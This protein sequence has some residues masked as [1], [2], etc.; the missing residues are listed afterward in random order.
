LH[1]AVEIDDREAGG[2]CVADELR[3]GA[4][5]DLPGG[6]GIQGGGVEVD[7]VR[8]ED[9]IGSDEG[10]VV[11]EKT[12]IDSGEGG[13]AKGSD[14]N[15]LVVPVRGPSVEYGNERSVVDAQGWSVAANEPIHVRVKSTVV[16]DDLAGAHKVEGQVE[17][18][19]GHGCGVN[20][21]PV[22]IRII[23]VFIECP[24]GGGVGEA[25]PLDDLEGE[26]DGKRSG[27][28]QKDQKDSG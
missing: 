22:G 21:R 13:V 18:G 12:A 14:T 10:V 16:A 2:Q 20:H 7:S 8:S 1:G 6:I 28:D 4:K 17:K 5:L 26:S 24:A 23:A 27:Q 11:S 9:A 25:V 15:W 19:G 3:V